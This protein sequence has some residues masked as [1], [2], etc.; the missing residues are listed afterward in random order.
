MNGNA[1]M[2]ALAA[3]A[4]QIVADYCRDDGS[5]LALYRRHEAL[6]AAGGAYEALA[7]GKDE[8]AELDALFWDEVNAIAAKMDALPS[9]TAADFAAKA[10][11]ATAKGGLSCDWETDSLWIEARALLDAA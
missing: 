6:V 1:E 4:R 3:E 2:L 11:V 5:I 10:I 8:N 7:S 9:V